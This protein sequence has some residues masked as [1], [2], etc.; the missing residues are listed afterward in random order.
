M[1]HP[2]EGA[3]PKPEAIILQAKHLP[4]HTN[5]SSL[6][7][8]F[9]PYGPIFLCK[10]V[11]EN[12]SAFEGTALIHYF[13]QLDADSALGAMN[14]SEIDGNLI[15]VVPFNPPTTRKRPQSMMLPPT[16][17]ISAF[18]NF[19]NSPGRENPIESPVD[20]KNLYIKN[21]DIGIKSP[22]LFNL[23]K[24]FGHVVS[25]RVMSNPATGYSKGYG[26][27][28]YT[29]P[30]SASNALQEMNGRMIGSKPLIVA[31]HEPK[32]PKPEKRMQASPP[33]S[34]SSTAYGQGAYSPPETS[35]SGSFPPQSFQ[36]SKPQMDSPPAGT[37]L[38]IIPNIEEEPENV[39]QVSERMRD[40]DIG[41]KA[42]TEA[43]GKLSQPKPSDKPRSLASLASLASGTAI[44]VSPPQLSGSNE[45]KVTMEGRPTLRRRNS[46]ESVSSVVTETSS[47]MKHQKMAEAV[48]QCGDYGNKVNDIVDML[49]T[50][51]RKDRSL[52]LF[53]EDFLREKI[54]LALEALETFD[55]E[56]EDEEEDEPVGYLPPSRV[57]RTHTSPPDLGRSRAN[58]RMSL[59]PNF[60]Y[61]MPPNNPA[62]AEIALPKRE[63]KAIPIVAP[64]PE[65]TRPKSEVAKKQP[66]PAAK[67]KGHDI[68]KFLDSI[69]EKPIHEQKQ[70]LGDRLFPLVK[71]TGTKQAPKVTIRLLDTID[72]RELAH[73]MYDQELLAGKVE[74]VFASM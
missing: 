51:K 6:Y 11:A 46:L 43:I 54:E 57:Q 34:W 21:L 35:D 37:G 25:A 49:L 18:G 36:D 24:G 23:F 8:L 3:N 67:E 62:L 33:E 32:K 60:A 5:N 55:E 65:Q 12:G 58:H 13:K 28:S 42:P 61:I 20:F 66:A 27:V 45:Y 41:Q 14:G 19:P 15:S 71:A 70:Q 39:N 64:P 53:N 2:S 44:A 69:K 30:V 63:S 50:L 26:F 9:R 73:L 17:K 22:D 16:S 56:E 59:P 4:L 1:H 68:D 7:D 74:A 29:S 38:N 52:C 48:M 40:L 47:A 10:T 31:F 72:L